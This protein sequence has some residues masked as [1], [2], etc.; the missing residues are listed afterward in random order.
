MKLFSKKT[1]RALDDLQENVGEASVS[2]WR[3][4]VRHFIKSIR[5]L[6][7]VRLQVVV[8]FLLLAVL[9]GAGSLQLTWSRAGFQTNAF[10][11]GGTFAEATL[12]EIRTTIPWFATTNSER[13]IARL[14][15][16]TLL[17]YDDSG[18]IR[19]DVASGWTSN[20]SA[21]IWTVTL[22]EGIYFHDGHPL[23]AD[24]VVFTIQM[25]QDPEVRAIGASGWA[26][27]EVAKIDD[28]TVEFTL[29]SG[30]AAFPEHLIFEILPK[31][32]LDQAPKTNLL[33]AAFNG[34]P[35]GSGPFTFSSIQRT[36]GT[37][38]AIVHLSANPRYH[39]GA[40]FLN[41][42]LIHAFTSHGDIQN[43]I[44]QGRVTAT[45]EL[46]H[47]HVTDLPNRLHIRQ[48]P[49]NE[50]VFAFFNTAQAP[51]NNRDIRRAL[52]YMTN[53][54]LIIQAT[55]AQITLGYPIL[56][57]QM[58]LDF[59]EVPTYDL[60]AAEE[61][62]ENAGFA[63]DRL[64][65]SSA[66]EDPLT[67]TM[68]TLDEGGLSAAATDLARQ[69]ESFGVTVDLHIY[70]DSQA[71]T[72]DRLIPRLYDVLI[73]NI[74]MGSD[75]DMQPFYHSSQGNGVGLNFSNFNNPTVDSIL[76]SANAT[77]NLITRRD[78]YND[79]LRVWATELPSIGLYRSSLF[80]VVNPNVRTFPDHTTFVTRW[81]RFN[82]IPQFAVNTEPRLRTP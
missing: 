23:T 62:L 47:P 67:V 65:Y 30:T 17:F 52:A 35:I 77:T 22:R 27:T 54:S 66:S 80:Y 64:W 71:F 46:G 43:A 37:A 44:Y 1:K 36:A 10:V 57:T 31:H 63:R 26:G 33:E 3:H 7:L 18:N 74:A 14:I 19:G 34:N 42:F 13:T 16:S 81:N 70:T 28:Y 20:D 69:W 60:F 5:G 53:K 50:G 32:A 75:P 58:A 56:P 51:L 59:P 6:H 40:P 8:W 4:F 24:D 29:R 76:A 11:P 61:Y 38:D 48:A 79:F 12:G 73:Y 41:S 2:V 45:A 21:N 15:Y 82:N 25:I 39:R 72:R 68:V 78:R 9:L 49:L 55:S